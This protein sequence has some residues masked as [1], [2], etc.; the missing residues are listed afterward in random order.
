[1][2]KMTKMDK[3]AMVFA[4]V[5]NA[6]ITDDAKA[7]ATDFIKHEM[8]LL[9]SKKGGTKVSKA[10]Q[11]RRDADKEKVLADFATLKGEGITVTEFL[12]LFGEHYKDT[13]GK[14]YSNSKMT[15]IFTRL[16]DG[17]SRVVGEKL[18]TKIKEGKK[19]LYKLV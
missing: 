4:I 11:A 17:N 16:G 15:S 19:S 10:E 9:S 3:F 6:D 7:I 18:I 12:E 14:T 1:M 13:E 2:T 8:D 5:N